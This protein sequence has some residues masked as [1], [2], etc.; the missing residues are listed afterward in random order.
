M[1]MAVGEGAV[2]CQYIKA[3]RG[4]RRHFQPAGGRG[5]R[6][7]GKMRGRWW[8]WPSVKWREARLFP[9]KSQN[10]LPSQSYTPWEGRRA[11]TSFKQI[12]VEF[13]FQFSLTTLSRNMSAENLKNAATQLRILSVESTTKAGSGHP[14]SCSSMADVISVLYFHVMR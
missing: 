10:N 5:S 8:R 11:A 4:T 2:K 12:F 14:T 6:R 3:A 7:S 1:S 13:Y 9:G